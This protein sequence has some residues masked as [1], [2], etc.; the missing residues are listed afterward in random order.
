MDLVGLEWEVYVCV[1][2]VDLNFERTR[3]VCIYMI[4]LDVVTLA[5]L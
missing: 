4:S 1:G 2:N 5:C 3:S